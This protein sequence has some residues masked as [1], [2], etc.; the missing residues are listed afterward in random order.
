MMEESVISAECDEPLH[1]SRELDGAP[2][3]GV[4]P[5]TARLSPHLTLGYRTT[6]ALRPRAVWIEGWRVNG[7]EFHRTQIGLNAGGPALA[8]WAWKNGASRLV[9]ESL[10]GAGAVHASYLHV[11]WA[12]Y[13][14]VATRFVSPA[15][16][17]A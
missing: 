8:A 9:T 13:P 4:L 15:A 7:H 14:A 5:L 1:P 11:H 6:V 3:C 16:E 10:A 17:V 2:M 12:T